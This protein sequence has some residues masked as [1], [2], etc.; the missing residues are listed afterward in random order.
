MVLGKPKG[1]YS[2]LEEN[3]EDVGGAPQYNG[4]LGEERSAKVM[5]EETRAQGAP[6][7]EQSNA[8]AAQ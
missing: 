8:P 2:T 7:Q 3:P 1:A 5:L 6:T 4:G